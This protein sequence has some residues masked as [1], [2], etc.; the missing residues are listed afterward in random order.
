MSMYEVEDLTEATIRLIDHLPISAQEKREKMHQAFAIHNAFDT[1]YIHF[2]LIDILLKNDY[3]QR[4][5]RRD[6]PLREKYPDFFDHLN[7]QSDPW[8]RQNP[9]EDWSNTNEAIAYWDS[10][11][12]YLYVDYQSPYYTHHPEEQPQE[13]PANVFALKMIEHADQLN[14]PEMIYNW[15]MMRILYLPEYFPS[16]HDGDTFQEMELPRIQAI[17]KRHDLGHVQ[18][19]HDSW[20]LKNLLSN[21]NHLE[22]LD[23]WQIAALKSLFPLL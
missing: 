23:D 18:P 21:C 16:S 3:V 9:N 13:V 1:S 17:W 14:N 7:G 19:F 11:S 22:W 20:D 6:F 15:T 8:I 4:Y 10:D 2:R 5:K 12:G